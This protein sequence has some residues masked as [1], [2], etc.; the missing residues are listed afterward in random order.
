MNLSEF[1]GCARTA[2]SLFNL[3]EIDKVKRERG[4]THPLK[5]DRFLAHPPENDRSRSSR[6]LQRP[7]APTRLR[8]RKRGGEDEW[9][10]TSS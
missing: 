7:V 9:I 6:R 5:S 1:G 10:V 8:L 4:Q 3:P 2:L